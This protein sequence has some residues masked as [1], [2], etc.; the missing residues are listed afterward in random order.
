MQLQSGLTQEKQSFQ[1]HEAVMLLSM[2]ITNR[3]ESKE[4]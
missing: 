2:P 3:A 1:Q 4:F